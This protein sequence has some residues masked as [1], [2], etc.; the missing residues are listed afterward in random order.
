MQ[1]RAAAQLTA[2][3]KRQKLAPRLRRREAGGGALSFA[4]LDAAAHIA[5]ILAKYAETLQPY[6]LRLGQRVGK[7]LASQRI[8]KNLIDAFAD[9]AIVEQRLNARIVIYAPAQ[10]A[11]AVQIQEAVGQQ[12]GAAV[13]AGRERRCA[14]DGVQC[15][16]EA[17]LRL[18][19]AQDFA[20]FAVL[21]LPQLQTVD[22][23]VAQLAD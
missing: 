22:H 16:P 13:Q 4:I 5:A 20:K 7:I 11:A 19:S 2:G 14:P 10:H 15:R 18:E 3:A 8:E 9:G 21:L 12:L 1:Q 23:R 6:K 17:I